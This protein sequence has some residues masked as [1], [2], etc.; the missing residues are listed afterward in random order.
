[1]PHVFQVAKRI[2]AHRPS[3]R[4]AVIRR[5]D[6]FVSDEGTVSARAKEGPT[7]TILSEIV[8]VS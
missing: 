8:I 7:E 5:Q 4:H 3:R 6:V 1:M 2:H